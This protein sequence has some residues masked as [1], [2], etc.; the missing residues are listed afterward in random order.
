[1][2]VY[3]LS[4]HLSDA[5]VLAEQFSQLLEQRVKSSGFIKTMLLR[6]V[7]SSMYAGLSTAIGMLNNWVNDSEDDEDD[8]DD[9]YR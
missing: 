7:C 1:M 2:K 8:Y 4:T 3:H 5:Y 9:E 6:R